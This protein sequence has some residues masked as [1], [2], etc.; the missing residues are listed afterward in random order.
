MEFNSYVWKIKKE[1]GIS[2]KESVSLSIPEE[3]KPFEKDL[4]ALHNIK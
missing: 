2:F 4:R 1:R 3:L